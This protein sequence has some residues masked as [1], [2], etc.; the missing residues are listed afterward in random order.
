MTDVRIR[1]VLPPL[2]GRGGLG[3]GSLLIFPASAEN[4]LPAS[5][6]KQGKKQCHAEQGHD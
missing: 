1:A 4:L 6:R 2:Q 3:R 5:P